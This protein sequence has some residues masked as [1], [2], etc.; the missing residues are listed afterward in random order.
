[1]AEALIDLDSGLNISAKEAEIVRGLEEDIIFGR[2]PPATR[3]IED[4]LMARFGVT[5]HFV[6]QALSHLERR[7]IVVRER[8]KSAAVRSLTPDEVEQI[9]DVRELLQRQAALRIPLPADPALLARLVEIQ[10][11]YRQCVQEDDFRGV[12]EHNDAFH[13]TLFSGSGNQHVVRSIQWYMRLSLLVR[14]KQMS[15]PQ[16]LDVS[17]RHHDMM[18][19]LLRG[20][21]GWALAQLCVEHIQPAKRAY[22][23]VVGGRPRAT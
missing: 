6:R 8:N 13:L 21:D 17:M 3:L 16:M 15:N 2:L 10:A 22:L 5:R 9:Y 23:A 4:P 12:H 1:M 11:R 7:G 19:E 14:A 20:R 18:I